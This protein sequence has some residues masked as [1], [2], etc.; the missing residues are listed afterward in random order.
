MKHSKKSIAKIT[1]SIFL[2]CLITGAHAGTGSEW[3]YSGD[4]GPEY[5]GDL[6]P[7]YAKC[8][9]GMEQSPINLSEATIFDDAKSLKSKF[10]DVPLSVINNGHTI[11]VNVDNGSFTKT[12]RGKQRLLQFHFHS[13][14]EHTLDGKSFPLEVHFVHIDDAGMLSVLGVFFKLG[15]ENDTLKAIL[16]I[17]PNHKGV[18]TAD[19]KMLDPNRVMGSKKT[20]EYYRVQGS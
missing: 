16:D 11:Q 7:E 1:A 8:K 18:A 4:N 9:N 15:E 12:E 3:S 6:S 5:W 20:E 10:D 13:L 19:G 2:S 14:S 17:A